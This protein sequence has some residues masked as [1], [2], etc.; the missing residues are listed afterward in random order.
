MPRLA[1]VGEPDR[2]RSSVDVGRVAALPQVVLRKSDTLAACP[3]DDDEKSVGGYQ[4]RE[5]ARA[6][7]P[8]VRSSP[9]PQ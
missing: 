1:T 2:E 3:D 5:I 8:I 6:R 9:C 4:A 7:G